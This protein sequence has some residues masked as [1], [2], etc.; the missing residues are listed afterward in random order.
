[1]PNLLYDTSFGVVRTNPKLTTNVKLVYNGKDI[2]LES[3]DANSQLSN[4]AYKGYKLSG[5]S[6]YDCDIYRFYHSGLSTPT[7][8]AYD[9]FEEFDETTVM[10]SFGNQYEMMYNMGTRSISSELYEEDFG[11]MFPLW[12]N[13]NNV[14]EYFVIFRIDGPTFTDYNDVTNFTNDRNTFNKILENATLIKTFDLTEN[15]VLGSYIR[16]YVNQEDFPKAPIYATSNENDPWEWCGISF[17]KGGFSKGSSF[18][19]EDLIVKDASLIENEYYITQGFERNRIICANLINIEFLFSDDSVEDYTINRYFGFY[20][21]KLDEG[22]FDIDGNGMFKCVDFKQKPRFNK[23]AGSITKNLEHKIFVENPN[24]VLLSIDVEDSNSIREDNKFISSE[25]V[26]SRNSLFYIQDKHGNFRS[27]KKSDKNVQ[28]WP[29]NHIRLKE[30]KVDISDFT[31]FKKPD[32]FAKCALI[33]HPGC[34]TSCI[35]ILDEISDCFSIEFND[36]SYIGYDWEETHG[37][38]TH[39]LIFEDKVVD[40]SVLSTDENVK[41]THTYNKIFGRKAGDKYTVHK[42]V[43]GVIT[44]ITL[45]EFS[46]GSSYYQYFCLSGSP[47]SVAKAIANAINVGIDEDHR[48]F[49]ATAVKNKVFVVAKFAGERMNA[50]RMRIDGDCFSSIKL[51]YNEN[52]SNIAKFIGGTSEPNS[53]LRIDKNDHLRF[54]EGMYVKTRN[55]YAKIIGYLPYTEKPLYDENGNVIEYKDIDQYETVFLDGGY[56]EMTNNRVIPLYTDFK[57]SIGR[58]SFFPIKDFDFDIYSKEYTACYDLLEEIK[59]YTTD[60]PGNNR[61]DTNPDIIKFYETGFSLIKNLNLENM[62][63]NEYDR[64]EEKYIKELATV[65]KVVPYINKWSYSKNGK[66]VRDTAYRLNFNLAFGQ[67]NFSPSIYYDERNQESFS[68]EWYYILGVPSYY[69][70]SNNDYESYEHL[71]HYIN[72]IYDENEDIVKNLENTSDNNFI[73][74][75]ISDSVTNNENETI[76]FTPNIKYSEFD[77]GDSQNFASTFFRGVK[78]IIKELTEKIEYNDIAVNLNNILY[79]PSSKY[80]TYKFSCVLAKRDETC[81]YIIKN[82]KWKTITI[83]CSLQY[84]TP[85]TSAVK[86][87]DRTT[88]YAI[89]SEYHEYM[90]ESSGNGLYVTDEYKYVDKEITDKIVYINCFDGGYAVVKGNELGS[91]ISTSSNGLYNDIEFFYTSIEGQSPKKYKIQFNENARIEVDDYNNTSYLHGFNIL[92]ENDNKIVK[93]FEYMSSNI[94]LING[95]KNYYKNRFSSVGFKN[96]YD[97]INSLNN[98]DVKYVSVDEYGNISN[99]TDFVLELVC[100]NDILKSKYITTIVDDKSPSNRNV[101]DIIGYS[102]SIDDVSIIPMSRHNGYY[103][104]MFRNIINFADI[105]IKHKYHT[106][107]NVIELCRYKN[108]EFNVKNEDFALIKNMFYHKT[109][110]ENSGGILEFS[111]D[112]AFNSVY[113]LINECGTSFKDMYTFSSSWDFGYFVKNLDREN[114]EFKSGTKSMVEKKS[115][116]GSKCMKLPK[117]ILIETFV[118]YI[119]FDMRY[120]EYQNYNNIVGDYMH[121]EDNNKVEL[122]VF[123][124]K[125]LEKYLYDELYEYFNKYIKP[126]HSYNNINTIE[127]DVYSYIENNI[128]KLYKRSDIYFFTKDTREDIENVYD[129]TMLTNEMKVLSGLELNNNAKI[130]DINDNS[131]DFM[132]SFNKRTGYSNYFGLS[133]RFTKK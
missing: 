100:Q 101:N 60:Y 95:Y 111:N 106:D 47:E 72:Y 129:T 7:E 103:E 120:T 1:M 112:S 84:D 121:T 69:K 126:E 91:N 62:D 10:S 19:Y 123:M 109:N 88:L 83:V 38:N 105:F 56:I 68:H 59:F 108:T 31:G 13:R 57:N 71:H 98:Y 30:T 52:G 110:E 21:N 80:N 116:F 37:K 15:S 8:I 34:A 118:P 114:I 99:E 115:F 42:N 128:L 55:G 70:D 27:I 35:E 82:E 102:L 96:I 87:L 124:K 20:V 43:D 50:L 61:I 89:S 25:E 63:G 26:N 45:H 130:K 3:F 46:E 122:Y 28:E 94:T 33:N 73:K 18:V 92:D 77:S 58:F 117:D 11:L 54:K 97:N 16:R 132:L 36:S 93:E 90:S 2:Y 44:D 48:F 104:P 78:V 51:H 119:E 23:E 86:N 79:T 5:K 75:F 4:S 64:L 127:D 14:P 39:S 74:Y 6:T 32:T 17:D 53:M 22:Q 107:K 125:R 12:I 81:V 113:P 9:V 66:N 49:K 24:G 65:S 41:Y 85:A 76:V 40:E 131:F 67:Y 29:E 133:V